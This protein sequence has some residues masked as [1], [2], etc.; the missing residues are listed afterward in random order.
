MAIASVHRGGVSTKAGCPQ[1]GVLLYFSVKL[2][3]WVI[4]MEGRVS[5]TLGTYMWSW[6]KYKLGRNQNCIEIGLQWP[7][8]KFWHLGILHASLPG[9]LIQDWLQFAEGL[10][11]TG[12]FWS[13]VNGPVIRANSIGLSWKLRLLRPEGRAGEAR[14]VALW[15]PDCL[16]WLPALNTAIDYQPTGSIVQPSMVRLRQPLLD[17]CSKCWTYCTKSGTRLGLNCQLG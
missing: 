4:H 10:Q 14:K 11:G 2:I 3:C 12:P 16:P 15:T 5:F 1:D 17:C 13:S 9:I 8:T 7:L 6:K